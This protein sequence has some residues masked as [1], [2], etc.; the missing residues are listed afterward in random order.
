MNLQLPVSRD[1]V[2]GGRVGN[3]MEAVLLPLVNIDWTIM[4]TA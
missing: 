3:I 1:K 4:S 2:R